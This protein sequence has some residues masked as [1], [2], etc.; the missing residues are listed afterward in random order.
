[1]AYL[2]PLAG[3]ESQLWSLFVVTFMDSGTFKGYPLQHRTFC[4][5]CPPTAFLLVPIQCASKAFSLLCEFKFHSET[6]GKDA[7]SHPPS[8]MRFTGKGSG[9][10]YTV[11]PCLVWNV[12]Y[13]S[14]GCILPSASPFPFR[15]FHYGMPWL[16]IAEVNKEE[17]ENPGRY[18][19]AR[20]CIS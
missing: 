10:V 12:F 14:P 16:F 9:H 7:H 13:W 6:Q 8:L 2:S 17:M 5:T 4:I 11:H 20:S 15:W 1:M 19:G 3:G 18:Q